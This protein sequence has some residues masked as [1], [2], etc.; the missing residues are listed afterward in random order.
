MKSHS[1]LLG[2]KELFSFKG[3]ATR[4]LT[5]LHCMDTHSMNC[6]QWLFVVFLLLLL[7]EITTLGKYVIRMH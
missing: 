7:Y 6:N 3:V 5:M 2:N 4:R 1:Q